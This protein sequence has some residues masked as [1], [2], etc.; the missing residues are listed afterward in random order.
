MFSKAMK[1][2]GA[3]AHA[4]CL[5]M[6][7]F[8]FLWQV[9]TSLKNPQQLATGSFWPMAVYWRNYAAV[10][11]GELSFARY[12]FNSFVVSSSTAMLSIAA[13]CLAAYALART[14]IKSKGLIMTAVLAM[15][16]FPQIAAISP[17]F[18]MLKGAGLLNTYF[19]LIIP[20][21]GFSLP[22]AI[23]ILTNF[24]R[25]LPVELE[26]AAA[27]DGAGHSQVI[28][29]VFLPLAAPG[30]F[31]AG[32]LVFIFC[33]NEFLLALTFNTAEQMRTVTVGIAMFPGQYEMPWGVIFAASVVVTIPLI[34][35]VLLLQ[36]R[37]VSG[38]LAGAVKS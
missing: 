1:Y 6:I 25:K 32:M 34:V 2:L 29:H 13:A 31:T 35:M 27:V 14:G 7:L 21:T 12:L 5:G 9:L 38:L 37:I 20:Y 15:A 16:M 26:E 11:S 36:K 24:F 33:W 19:G 10:F 17:L 22:M 8:P 3:I 23:W 28:R 4:T 18:L 30:I